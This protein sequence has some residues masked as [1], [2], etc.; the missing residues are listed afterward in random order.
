MHNQAGMNIIGIKCLGDYST[1]GQPIYLNFNSLLLPSSAS[2][3]FN[4]ARILSPA[5]VQHSLI[6]AVSNNIIS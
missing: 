2:S 6:N 4:V 3:Y 1:F 5:R